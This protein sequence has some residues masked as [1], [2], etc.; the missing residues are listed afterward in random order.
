MQLDVIQQLKEQQ[1]LREEINDHLHT[2]NLFNN[3]YR[4][5]SEKFFEFIE[6]ARQMFAEGLLD[7]LDDFD[8]EL[9]ASDIGDFATVN[10]EQVP[11]DIP[12]LDEAEK[13]GRDVELNKPM[14]SSGPKKFKVYVRN[15]DTGEIITVNFGAKD[16]GQNL[17]VKLDDPEARKAF[18]KRHKCDKRDDK[19]KPSYWSCRLPYYAKQLGLSGGGNY[20]W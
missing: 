11:L 13:N 8:M 16:G 3:Q 14:R 7:D 15:P 6:E 5:F 17:A 9:I 18:A 4:L 20:Y 12:I 10:G 19:T 2:D 1:L